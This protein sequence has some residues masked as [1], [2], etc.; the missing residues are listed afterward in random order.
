MFLLVRTDFTPPPELNEDQLSELRE[1]EA[2]AAASLQE[3][4]V[5]R[6]L[7][8]DL[9]TGAAWGVWSIPDGEDLQKY[10]AELPCSPYMKTTVHPIAPHPN[11]VPVN[12]TIQED[13]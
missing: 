13:V 10:Q 6:H 4:G 3:R 1:A 5:I 2:L 11:R 8:R 7:W 12:R 9:E